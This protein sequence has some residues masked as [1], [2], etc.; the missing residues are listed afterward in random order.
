[1]MKK[2]YSKK[3]EKFWNRPYHSPNV[4]SV[5]FRLKKYLLD[6]YIKANKKLCVLDYGCGEG[7]NIR[8]FIDSF[9]Y[10]GYGVDISKS[11][12]DYCKKYINKKNFKLIKF[13]PVNEDDDFF[14]RKFDLII[15]MQVLYFLSNDDL[16]K[17]LKSLNKMLKPNG[18]VF[19]TMKSKKNE[20]WKFSNKKKDLDGLSKVN[21]G[22]HSDYKKRQKQSIY[23]HYINFCSNTKEMKKKF[24]IFKPIQTGFY[25]FNYFSN[26]FKHHHFTFFGKKKSK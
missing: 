19:F 24:E 9:K 8:Y 6:K 17:R 13:S 21:L 1:M 4:E 12:I 16:N 14:N 22:N 5:I 23:D 25:D 20:Y 10:E 26:E 11:S 2:N 7:A 3:N 18:Y 15:S